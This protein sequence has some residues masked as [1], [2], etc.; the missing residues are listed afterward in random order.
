MKELVTLVGQDTGVTGVEGKE[1]PI[2]V[3]G[4]ILTTKSI[5]CSSE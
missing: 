5:G 3:V 4:C 2:A 1:G